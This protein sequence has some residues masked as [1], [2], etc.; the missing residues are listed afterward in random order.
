MFNNDIYDLAGV[1]FDID[2]LVAACAE[3]L[4]V[5]EEHPGE[6]VN[7]ISLTK[8]AD[9]EEIERRGIFW[10]KNEDYVEEEREKH[11]DESKYTELAP[12]VRN[13]YLEKVIEELRARFKLGRIRLLTLN[14]RNSLSFHRDP[15]PRVHVP[16][17]SNPGSLVIVDKFCTHLP[18][19]GCAYY[20]NT[21]KYHTALN[22]GESVRLHLV[23]TIIE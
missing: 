4:S 20:M 23:A 17:I 16:I 8:M 11:V 1:R 18:A 10:I 13:T 6:L 2:E 5:S 22:G 7:A 15:E 21:K 9:S 19:N 12:V 14:P 3:V